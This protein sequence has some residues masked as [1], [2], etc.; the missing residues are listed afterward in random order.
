MTTTWNYLKYSISLALVL[1]LLWSCTQSDYTKLVKSELQKG[2][3]K[4][5]LLLGINLGDTRDEFYGKCFDL[6]HDSLVTQGPNGA[7]VQ[8]M[9]ED[10]L[11]HD[12]I[13]SMR[14]LFIPVFDEQDKIIEMNLEFSYPAWAPWNTKYQSDQLRD[15]VLALVMRWYK[16]NEFI[17]A[18]INKTQIPVKIDGNRRMLVYIKDAQNVVVKIQD[19][20]HPRYKHS[21]TEDGEKKD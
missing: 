9:F 17:T 12:S 4:D 3:R 10:T 1:G 14:L 21:I 20:L 19:I 16:G 5:S 7:T 11:V 2:I 13:T 6:N 15:K 8:Y 18:T